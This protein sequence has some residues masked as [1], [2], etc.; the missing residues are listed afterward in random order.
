[1]PQ[2]IDCTSSPDPDQ[3]AAA[4]SPATS[5][6]ALSQH[7]LAA[8]PIP[9]PSRAVS[10][11]LRPFRQVSGVQAE[12]RPAPPPANTAAYQPAGYEP[13]GERV[14]VEECK[15]KVEKTEM[16]SGDEDSASLDAALDHVAE[17]EGAGAYSETSVGSEPYPSMELE[18]IGGAQMPPAQR[19]GELPTRQAFSSV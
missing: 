8:S 12:T 16:M 11:Q 18:G 3:P 17:F 15:V 13:T 7:S 1:M 2:V 14:D 4:L 6:G 9:S 19:N 10:D 5:G